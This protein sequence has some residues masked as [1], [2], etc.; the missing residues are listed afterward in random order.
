M[1]VIRK[2]SGSTVRPLIFLIISRNSEYSISNF[3]RCGLLQLC[4]FLRK[5]TV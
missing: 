1:K 4:C 2:S 3:P 5:A